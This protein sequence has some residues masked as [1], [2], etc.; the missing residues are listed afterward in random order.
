MRECKIDELYIDK[1]KSSCANIH[2]RK[3]IDGNIFISNSIS[4]N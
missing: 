1:C 3:G 4:D 2:E